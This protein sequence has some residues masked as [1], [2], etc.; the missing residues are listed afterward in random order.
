MNAHP[1]LNINELYGNAKVEVRQ[2]G[3]GAWLVKILA[4]GDEY[5]IIHSNRERCRLVKLCW[6]RYGIRI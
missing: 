3:D 4:P 2:C 1:C 5:P 6:D